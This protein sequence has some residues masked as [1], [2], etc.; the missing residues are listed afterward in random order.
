[1]PHTLVG[2]PPQ[3]LAQGLL[4]ASGAVIG[5]P[6]SAFMASL[7]P[8]FALPRRRKSAAERREQRLRAEA[9]SIQKF[10]I[11]QLHGHR[12]SEPTLIGFALSR[13]LQT[14]VPREASSSESMPTSVVHPAHGF[15]QSAPSA[16]VPPPAVSR[17]VVQTPNRETAPGRPQVTV[18]TSAA[19]SSAAGVVLTTVSQIGRTQP[20]RPPGC[21]I[22]QP[23]GSDPFVQRSP[24]SGFDAPGQDVSDG[25]DDDWCDRLSSMKPATERA[26]VNRGTGHGT[27]KNHM[28]IIY[29]LRVLTRSRCSP[30]S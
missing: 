2:V 19:S 4:V 25:E 11:A 17:D 5:V 22:S 16:V 6:P 24:F 30:A 7:H 21:F 1:M 9:R 12:G 15:P 8:T 29:V 13:V 23:M 3:V 18:D 26:R 20:D 28:A 14:E 27:Q 10:G